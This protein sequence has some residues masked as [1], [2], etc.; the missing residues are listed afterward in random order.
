MPENPF[1]IGDHVTGPFFTDRAAEVRRILDAMRHPTRLLVF[2]ARRMGKSSALG[3]AAARARDEGV[4]VVRADLATTSSL[5]DVSNRLLHSLSGQRTK[6]R[7]ASFAAGLAPNVSLTF[8]TKTGAARLAFGVERRRAPEEGQRRSLEEVVEGLA[9]EASSRGDRIAVVLDEFQAIGR[10]GGETAEWHLRDL[11]QRHGLLSFVCAGSELSLIH[12]MLGKD[13]AFFRAF[14]LLHLGAIDPGHLGRWIDERL[15]GAGV[16]AAGV[17]EAVIGAVGPRT[18]D[19]LQVARHVYGR[20]AGRG[21]ALASDVEEAVWDVVREE[22]PV[23]R[24]TWL[25]LTAHQQNVLRALAGNVD[26]L[27]STATRERFGLPTSSSVSAAV[28]ALESRGLVFRGEEGAIGFDSPF[29]RLWV[30]REALPDVPP[31]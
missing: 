7:L 9:G 30:E 22:E 24:A 20:A 19:I 21:E 14:E 4:L 17:G 15:E 31:A 5:V 1:R 6:E 3:V 23:I 2:G 28:D 25:N 29:V 26:Q 27:F 16:K 18:Q 10:F 8:D 11:M 13:R 12:E